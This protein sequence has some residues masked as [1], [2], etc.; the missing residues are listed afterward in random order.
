MGSGWTMQVRLPRFV[1][2][3]LGS[4]LATRPVVQTRRRVLESKR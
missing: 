1:R 3:S 4:R 2:A